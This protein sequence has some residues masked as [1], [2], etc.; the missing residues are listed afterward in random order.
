MVEPQAPQGGALYLVDHGE[1]PAVG[2]PRGKRRELLPDDLHGSGAVRR[3]FIR[4]VTQIVERA[5]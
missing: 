3:V 2:V 4:R 1:R 5:K